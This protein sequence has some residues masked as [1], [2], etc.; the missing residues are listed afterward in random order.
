M[1]QKRGGLIETRGQG[2]LAVAHRKLAETR[3]G[4]RPDSR[5]PH[6]PLPNNFEK[7]HERLFRNVDILF[8]P[9]AKT[10]CSDMRCRCTAVE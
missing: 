1:P 3:A 2:F 6:R 8:E 7:L 10:E 5:R 9:S 4:L